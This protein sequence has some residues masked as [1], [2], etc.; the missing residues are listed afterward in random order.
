MIGG[1]NEYMTVTEAAKELGMSVGALR[2]RLLR[3]HMRG[4][5][6]SPKLWLIPR[7]EVER[8]KAEGRMKPG[9]KTGRIEKAKEHQS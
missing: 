8:A 5:H 6:V 1:M 2:M 4:T 7:E 3:G 9:P